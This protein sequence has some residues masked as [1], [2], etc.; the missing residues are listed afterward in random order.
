INKFM[1]INNGCNGT[2]ISCFNTSQT[3]ENLTAG[4]NYRIRLFRTA[5]AA[6]NSS[7][8]SFTIK[9]DVPIVNI[10]DANFKNYLINNTS[11]N[12]NGDSEIQVSEAVA[13][14]GIINVRF[15]NIN[16]LTG[17]E[18]FTQLTELN[19][20][21]NNLTSLNVSSNTLLTYLNCNSNSIS[22]LNVSNN[23]VL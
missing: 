3:I 21:N 13:Y 20:E 6:S 2:I 17:I 23:T 9:Y 8:L 18:A 16:D 12:T 7:Y 19:C 4:T 22:L 5:I 14:N 11:I 15:K 1:L 10:P